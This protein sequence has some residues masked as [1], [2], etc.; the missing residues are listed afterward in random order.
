MLST[1]FFQGIPCLHDEVVMEVMWGMK[2]FMSKFVPAEESKLPK[3]DS[4]PMSQ[5][6]LMF[7]SRYGFD[8]KPEMVS[9]LLVA[10]LCFIAPCHLVLHLTMA[11]A[12]EHTWNPSFFTSFGC[13]VLQTKMPL[14]LFFFK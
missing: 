5:G 8:V 13:N 4:L 6:L 1:T 3:E 11:I 9:R 14:L 10:I 2:R 12:C 7:L